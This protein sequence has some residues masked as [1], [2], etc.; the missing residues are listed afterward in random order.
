LTPDEVTVLG[1]IIETGNLAISEKRIKSIAKRC[2]M[3]GDRAFNAIMVLNGKG[4][5]FIPIEG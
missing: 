2:N 1:E 4:V 3:S 5:I